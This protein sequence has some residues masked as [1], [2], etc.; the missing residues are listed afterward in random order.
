MECL[1]IVFLSKSELCDLKKSISTIELLIGVLGNLLKMENSI[2]LLRLLIF[3]ALCK[4]LT[5]VKMCFDVR[6][7]FFN[8]TLQIGQGLL[9]FTIMIPRQASLHI[10]LLVELLVI[11]F[12]LLL[13]QKLNCFGVS[14]GGFCEIFLRFM[15]IANS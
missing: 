15:A 4:Q 3:Y 2:S 1:V 13:P 8:D 11:R 6:S 14:L 7:I 9:I 12:R 5:N 10:A